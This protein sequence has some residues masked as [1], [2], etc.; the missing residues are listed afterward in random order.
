MREFIIF[1]IISWKKGTFWKSLKCTDWTHKEKFFKKVSTFDSGFYF[2]CQEK[3][4]GNS[5][6]RMLLILQIKYPTLM[7][8]PSIG[9]KWFWTIQIVLVGSK[10]FWWSSNHFGQVK[11]DFPWLFFIIWTFPKWFG[12][13]QNE[14]DPSKTIGTRPKSFWTHRRTRLY[15]TC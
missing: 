15:S 9:P 14:L 1:S 12:P 7:P 13:N 4:G 8:C 3:Y 5:F 6:N 10:L 2:I 11:L